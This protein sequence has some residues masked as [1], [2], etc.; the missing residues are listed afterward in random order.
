MLIFKDGA[1]VSSQSLLGPYVDLGVY[2]PPI[3]GLSRQESYLA[4]ASE[5]RSQTY[6]ILSGSCKGLHSHSIPKLQPRT[7]SKS[8]F[9]SFCRDIAL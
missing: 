8:F 6:N 5:R 7:A 4:G 2:H 9:L 3:E 1:L